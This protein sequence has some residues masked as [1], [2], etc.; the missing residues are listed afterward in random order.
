M[1]IY[2]NIRKEQMG[3]LNHCLGQNRATLQSIRVCNILY[4]I[5]QP[6]KASEWAW[7]HLFYFGLSFFICLSSNAI[8]TSFE[9]PVVGHFIPYIMCLYIT[10]EIFFFNILRII[11]IL[12]LTYAIKIVSYFPS[13]CSSE[14]KSYFL[15][16]FVVWR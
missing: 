13:F 9:V 14:I 16:F 7:S 4:M 12:E 5:D 11:D 15:T 3:F 6:F 1:L 10:W 8:Q 2:R